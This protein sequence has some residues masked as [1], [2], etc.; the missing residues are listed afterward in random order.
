LDACSVPI[1]IIVRFDDE[2]R[3]REKKLWFTFKSW[4]TI[5]SKQCLR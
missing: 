3:S 1:K 2:F 5:H 4:M